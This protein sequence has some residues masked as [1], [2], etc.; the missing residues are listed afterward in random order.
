MPV[1][2]LG[3][4]VE[5][6]LVVLVS[7]LLIADERWEGSEETGIVKWGKRL[8][9]SA[10][11]GF[12]IGAFAGAWCCLTILDWSLEVS[13]SLYSPLSFKTRAYVYCSV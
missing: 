1:I 3:I 6:L 8:T 10:C 12:F 7:V 5:I 13:S 4:L 11:N 9:K 2:C